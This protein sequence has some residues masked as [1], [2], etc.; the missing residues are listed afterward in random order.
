MKEDNI[1]GIRLVIAGI[2]VFFVFFVLIQ[3]FFDESKKF[4]PVSLNHS[5]M[6]AVLW[7]III[8]FSLTFLYILG[9]NIIKLYYGKSK[10]YAGGRFKKRLVISFIAISIIPTLSLFVF[11]TNLI[12]DGIDKWFAPDIESIMNKFEDLNRSYYE[13]AKDDLEHFS[14]LIAEDIKSKRK[15]TPENSIY[16][17]NSVKRQ[18]KEY[19]LHV[20]NIYRNQTELVSLISPE[21]PLHEYE[22]LPTEFVYK[23]LGGS[24]PTQTDNLTEGVLIRSGDHFTTKENDEIMV[25]IG[26]YFPEKYIKNLN[27]LTIM[28]RNYTLNKK[29]KDDIK[30]TYLLLFI[31]ITILIIFSASWLGLYLARGITTP[32]EKV[33][34]AAAEIAGGN[35]EVRIDYQAKDEFNTLIREF[36]RMVSDLKENRD[37]LDRSTIELGQRRSITENILENITTGVIAL[38]SRG[39]MIDINPAAE[40]MLSL[41]A[42]KVLKKHFSGAGSGDSFKTITQLVEKAY[43]TNLKLIEKEFNVKMGGKILNLAARITQ[44]RNPVDNK[45]AGILVVLTDLTELMQAQRM[46][47]WREVAKRIA[48]EIKNPLTPITI[49]SQRILKALELPDDK[50]RKLVED[51]LH[52]ILQELDSIT[53]LAEEFGDFARL[54]VV[55]FSKGDINQV[56]EKLLSVYSSIYSDIEFKVNFDLEMPILVKIDPEQ[57]KRVFVNIMDNSIEA[58]KEKGTIEILSKY[59]KETQ[60]VR[61]EIA[62]NGPGI[63]DENKQK[64]FVPYFSNKS[65]GTGLGLAIAHNI[66]EEHS[67]L[68]AVVDNEPQGVRFVIEIPA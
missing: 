30:T 35:L 39:E 22:D 9:R 5:T 8:L 2:S 16:L 65:S 68:I 43:S 18:M 17:H 45:F 67:G 46:L 55:K 25:I 64:L 13:K 49:S 62:D 23:E 29:I 28:V 38:D 36:N 52:I 20:V 63:S 48:H 14:K 4:S 66:I 31:F 42:G 51:S 44:I 27:S 21:I 26:M 41:D 6:F 33:V 58:L 19:K 61:V 53:K 57:M 10:G 7:A 24:N 40:R 56:L 11:A 34:A 12:N 32:I 3:I 15:Y 54:P 50:F 1:K 59:D 47:V 60:F 37:Q